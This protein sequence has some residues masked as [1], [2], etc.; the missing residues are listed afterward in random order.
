MNNIKKL[1]KMSGNVE[2]GK[3]TILTVELN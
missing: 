3:D 2:K 1:E